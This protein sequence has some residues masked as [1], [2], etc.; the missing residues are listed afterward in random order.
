[1]RLFDAILDA[2]HRA[3]AGDNSTGV[4][5]RGVAIPPQTAILIA[6]YESL[7]RIT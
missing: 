6:A 5:V 1:M 3:I 7:R 4:H 2:N